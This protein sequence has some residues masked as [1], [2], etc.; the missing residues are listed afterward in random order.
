MML[1][2][3]D[4]NKPLISGFS[5]VLID[6]DLVARTGGIRLL[7]HA[8]ADGPLEMAPMISSAFI[9]IADSP[10]TRAYLHPGTDLEVRLHISIVCVIN[11]NNGIDGL[12][13]CDGRLRQRS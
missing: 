10:L 12:V 2:A 9:F 6:I 11:T 5:I 8:L 4:V 3:F 13:R 7:L 1:L